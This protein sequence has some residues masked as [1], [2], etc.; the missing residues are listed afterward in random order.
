MAVYCL[1]QNRIEQFRQT[2]AA[3][4]QLPA[5]RVPPL[6]TRWRDIPDDVGDG[7]PSRSLSVAR[8]PRDGSL[9]VL[10][11]LVSVRARLV[12]ESVAT[13]L[14]SVN[15][16]GFQ[17][18]FGALT[19]QEGS[20]RVGSCLP[21]LSIN[22]STKIPE[23][24]PTGGI[25]DQLIP[26]RSL[27]RFFAHQSRIR[28]DERS[29]RWAARVN[30]PQPIWWLVMS[31]RKWTS[32]STRGRAGAQDRDGLAG[33]RIQTLSM[34]TRRCRRSRYRFRSF[35]P[36]GGS[37]YAIRHSFH[38]GPRP[39]TH[40]VLIRGLAHAR[41]HRVGP[42]SVLAS[43]SP[44]FKICAIRA[45]MRGLIAAQRTTVWWPLSPQAVQLF[46]RGG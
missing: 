27:G 43:V 34:W 40:C 25:D 44:G 13:G 17:L 21:V 18:D 36:S 33:V 4:G 37:S 20:Q 35:W 15:F 42:G 31:P 2:I 29:R 46:A 1:P 3:F 22:E 10:Y 39:K 38:C 24:V 6:H 30:K 5:H 8:L 9:P 23:G 32:S 12:K 26:P 16:L 7:L 41:L 19:S 11:R 14:P 45:A 28:G